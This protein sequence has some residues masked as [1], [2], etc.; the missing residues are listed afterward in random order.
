M[1]DKFFGVIKLVSGEEIVAKLSPVEDSDKILLE[2]PAMMTSTFGR[3]PGV[4]IIKIEPWIKTGREHTYIVEMEKVITT[5][6]ILENDV[7]QSYEK[8]VDAYYNGVE[9]KPHLKNISKEMGYVS[10]VKDARNV[11][12]KIFKESPKQ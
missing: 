6:E 12:E 10:S 9:P 11:L 1:T 7:I 8:F 4:N 2:C 3:R 5:C